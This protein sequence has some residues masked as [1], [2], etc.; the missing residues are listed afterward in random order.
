MALNLTVNR[1]SVDAT[2]DPSVIG[3]LSVLG[4]PAQ[5]KLEAG[6]FE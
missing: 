3:Q 4:T 5:R 6:I 1:L 2:H